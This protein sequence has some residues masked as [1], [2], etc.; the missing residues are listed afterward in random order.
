VD[1][2]EVIN[3]PQTMI[4]SSRRYWIHFVCNNFLPIF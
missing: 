3:L 2:D 1:E 4:V